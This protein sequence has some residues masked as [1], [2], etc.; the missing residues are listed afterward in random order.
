MENKELKYL[1]ERAIKN[2]EDA[3]AFYMGLHDRVSAP[4]AKEALLFLAKEEQK[5]RDFLVSYRDGKYAMSSLKMSEV[6]DYKIAQHVDS[7][8]IEKNMETKDVYL[9]AAHRELNSHNF[10]KNLAGIQPEGEV[11]DMLSRM[12]AEEL[13]HKEKVEYLYANTAFPQTQGG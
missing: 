2:E 13:K 7:P 5:H 12:A 8:D 4:E 10:Y 11:K 3:H 1:I 6:I 9:V